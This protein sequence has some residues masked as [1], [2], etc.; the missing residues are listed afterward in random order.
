LDQPWHGAK[1]RRL[2]KER[3]GEREGSGARLKEREREKEKRSG[4]ITHRVDRTQGTST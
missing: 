3:D 1:K 2:R 4:G